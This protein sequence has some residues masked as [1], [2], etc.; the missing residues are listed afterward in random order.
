ME[1]VLFVCCSQRSKGRW[2]EK[3]NEQSETEGVEW[4]SILT[5]W[6]LPLRTS[7]PKSL[8]RSQNKVWKHDRHSWPF[9][10]HL[11]LRCPLDL[12]TLTAA[13]WRCSCD[14]ASHPEATRLMWEA[15]Q[16]RIQKTS[17]NTNSLL[18]WMPLE[19]LHLS[20]G[21]RKNSTGDSGLW[22]HK[23]PT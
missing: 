18:W 11:V 12:H 2:T 9:E 19:A 17:G 20:A 16:G 5:E 15:I 10:R 8:S 23:C 22:Q 4:V 21:N 3:R 7:W 14:P 13:T 6:K 1:L